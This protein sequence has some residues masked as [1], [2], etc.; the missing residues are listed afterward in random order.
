MSDGVS[1]KDFREIA[2]LS[3]DVGSMKTDIAEIKTQCQSAKRAMLLMSQ[4]GRI[5]PM[6]D[7]QE[8]FKAAA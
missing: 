8:D 3:A 2:T 4:D 1:E 5:G 6:G 7:W